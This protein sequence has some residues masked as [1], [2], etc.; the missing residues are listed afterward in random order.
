MKRKIKI[1][2]DG[3]TFTGTISD[4][5]SPKTATAILDILPLE[6]TPIR[7]G[8][9]FYFE[10]PVSVEHE[11]AT[12]DIAVGDIA[13]WPPGRALCIFFGRTPISVNDNPK[14]ASAVN[15]VGSIYDVKKLNKLK[16]ASKIKIKLS[17]IPN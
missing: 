7:W 12:E 13:Y 17:E 6:S 3:T 14:P 4:K 2:I 10:I 1:I 9:E 16:I 8:G 5:Y 11:N 15:I